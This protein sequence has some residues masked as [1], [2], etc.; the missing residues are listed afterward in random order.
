MVAISAEFLSPPRTSAAAVFGGLIDISRLF[1]PGARSTPVVCSACQT[2]NRRTAEK[3]KGCDGKLP[4]YYA[5]G[6]CVQPGAATTAT[7]SPPTRT[8]GVPAQWVTVAWASALVIILFTTFGFWFERYTST[9]R[10]APSM[11]AVP[12]AA[13]AAPLLELPTPLRAAGSLQIE[14]RPIR[15]VS[16]P[17]E[18]SPRPAEV[19]S[20]PSTA[21]HSPAPGR[22]AVPT[23]LT[24][25]HT[26]SSV[27]AVASQRVAGDPIA[28]CLSRSFFARAVCL[29]NS[30]ARRA[31][32]HHPSCAQVV[33]QRRLDEARRNP[34]MLN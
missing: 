10:R 32:A 31:L 9:A 25:L 13:A 4:A 11:D 1:F 14:A 21:R 12:R 6:G 28:H 19:R 26:A 15:V 30:C 29:N 2:L 24:A 5:A 34:V 20:V 27:D 18:M 8:F 3:C 23:R 16:L 7:M 33:A 22:P 17:D